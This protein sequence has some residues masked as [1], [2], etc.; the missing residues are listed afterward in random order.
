MSAQAYS[1]L[2]RFQIEHHFAAK[3]EVLCR[4]LVDPDYIE[5]AMGRLPDIGNPVVIS[6]KQD[7]EA[8]RQQVRF[9]FTGSLPG[10][11]TAVIDTKRLTWIE[12]STID[13]QTYSATFSMKPDHYPKL[14]K[15]SGTWRILPDN[16]GSVRTLSAELKVNSPIPFTSGEVEKGI[17]SGLRDRLAK[18]PAVFADWLK[19][20][21][22]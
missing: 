10:V 2:V 12:E 7:Q 6:R 19:S 13:L 1:S 5:R 9:S 22:S 8:V 14:L 21:T 4:A 18:E 17:V 11:V 15:C 20:R 16:K 3:P